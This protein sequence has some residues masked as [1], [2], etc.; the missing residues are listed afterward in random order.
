MEKNE[1]EKWKELFEIMLQERNYYK[2]LLVDLLSKLNVESE[3]D[4]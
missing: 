2:D 4:E 1:V 3:E